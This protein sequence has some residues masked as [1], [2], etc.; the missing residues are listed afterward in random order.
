MEDEVARHATPTHQQA[1]HHLWGQLVAKRLCVF[2][3]R[4]LAPSHK[5]DVVGVSAGGAECQRVARDLWS[6]NLLQGLRPSFIPGVCLC[7]AYLH[8]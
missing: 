3:P 2:D 1:V 5:V 8:G 4:R 6:T 7:T